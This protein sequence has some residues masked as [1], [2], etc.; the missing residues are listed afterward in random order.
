MGANSTIEIFS[1]VRIGGTKG[2]YNSRAR[3]HLLMGN[4]IR[5]FHN[6]PNFEEPQLIAVIETAARRDEFA[7]KKGNIFP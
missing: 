7:N 1:T 5:C 4:Q 2:V 6:F 3:A